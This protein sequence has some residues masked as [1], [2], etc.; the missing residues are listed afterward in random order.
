MDIPSLGVLLEVQL[1]AYA[2]ATAT[3]DPS[4]IC[5]LHH[6]S[7]QCQI[8]D[9]LSEAKDLTFIFMD[10]SQIYF[11]FIFIF[12]DTSQIY[13]RCATMGNPYFDLLLTWPHH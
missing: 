7:Q 5:D 4:C 3:Q 2:T 10:T 1:P 11:H 6:S 12:M 8:P 13:F 9:S